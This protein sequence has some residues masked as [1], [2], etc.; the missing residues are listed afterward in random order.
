MKHSLTKSLALTLTVLFMTACASDYSKEEAKVITSNKDKVVALLNS[1]ETGD[2][3]AVAYI[4]A[5]N[6]KQHNLTIAD[7]L[8]GFGAVL[9]ALPKGSARVNVVRAFSDGN[10]VFTHTDY[11]F[12]GPKVGFDVFRFEDGL[13]V[14]HWDNLVETAK[15]PNPSSHTQID[16]SVDLQDLDKTK[17]NKALVA[18]FVDSILV[19]G[20]MDKLSQFFDGDNYIEHN[21]AIADG[22]SGLGAALGAMAKQGI[23]MVYSDVHTVLGEGNFVLSIS[24]GSFAGKPT[25]FYDL[26]RIENG[27]IAE[28]WDILETIIPE[29]QRKNANGKFGGLK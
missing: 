8:A 13:I 17:Q 19:K 11:N 16:G 24:E 22:L 18:D 29:D 9:Q 27:K 3:S 26:F 28:H 5:K 14:E 23:T 1:I 10:F 7:G 4:N 6:Y 20:E 25:S 12:F 2:Q 15:K 21:T